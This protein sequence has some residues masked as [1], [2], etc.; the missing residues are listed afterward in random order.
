[1]TSPEP[2]DAAAHLDAA[3][4]A[5]GLTR[6]NYTRQAARDKVAA[7]RA[8]MNQPDAWDRIREAHAARI[9]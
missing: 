6:T 7:A 3:L 9:A 4:D 8:R 1:M 2:P 5:R